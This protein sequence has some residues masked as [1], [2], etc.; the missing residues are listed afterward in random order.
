MENLRQVKAI[1][2]DWDDTKAATFRTCFRMYES[3][4]LE[5]N[6]PS[7]SE[8]L[9]RVHW[10]KP[11]PLLIKALWPDVSSQELQGSF[12]R[13]MEQIDFCVEPF[14]NIRETI[15]EIKRMGYLLGVISAS[16]RRGIN[17]TMERFLKLPQDTYYFIYAAEDCVAHKPD[18]RVFDNAFIELNK[19]G[20]REPQSLYIGDSLSDYRAA[21]ARGIVFTAVTTG[22]TTREQFLSEGLPSGLLLGSL[23]NLP[24]LLRMS[25]ENDTNH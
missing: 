13:Y 7:P 11:I 5:K 18:P 9:V 21:R 4:S 23:N 12:Y 8:E 1:I 2:F 10:G 17:R 14:P 16:D 20:I 19:I 22:L 24:E 6:F 3:F 25:S 15:L